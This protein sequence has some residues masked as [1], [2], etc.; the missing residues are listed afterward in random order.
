VYLSD[1]AG[2]EAAADWTWVLGPQPITLISES[3][4]PAQAPAPYG[5][6]L[7]TYLDLGNGPDLD[8][9]MLIVSDEHVVLPEQ[10]ARRLM[11]PPGTL[12]YAPTAG[13]DLRTLANTYLVNGDTASIQTAIANQCLADERVQSVNVAVTPIKGSL[14]VSIK[15]MGSAGPFGIVFNVGNESINSLSVTG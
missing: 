11:M 1:P 7:R 14:N 10:L 8:P 13:F 12:A 15:G 6:D 4:T 3:V 2:L 5:S 9:Y